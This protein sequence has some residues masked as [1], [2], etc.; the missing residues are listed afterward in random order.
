MT[1]VFI[2]RQCVGLLYNACACTYLNSSTAFPYHIIKNL[3]C[4]NGYEHCN[5]EYVEEV[6]NLHIPVNFK[7]KL[8]QESIRQKESKQI[9][10]NKNR[11][12]KRGRGRPKRNA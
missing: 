11:G 6:T 12:K 10:R 2:C 5:W 3:K 9:K 8:T 1:F 4:P 7:S